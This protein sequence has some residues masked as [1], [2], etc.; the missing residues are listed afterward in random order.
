MCLRVKNY[1]THKASPWQGRLTY[2]A[3]GKFTFKDLE[4]IEE[5]KRDC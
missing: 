3:V 4:R 2:P 1:K 5:S